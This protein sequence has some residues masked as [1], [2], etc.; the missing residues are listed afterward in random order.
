VVC[1]IY[2]FY[3]VC[4]LKHADV[5]TL[6]LV[7]LELLIIKF[8]VKLRFTENALTLIAK[9]AM[10]KNTGARGLRAILE[11]VLTEAM[12]EVDMGPCIMLCNLCLF[13]YLFIFIFIF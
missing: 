6:Y 5:L 4:G 11:N 8:Q 7:L 13:I 1:K 10:A 3:P 9:K 12:Y 2:S